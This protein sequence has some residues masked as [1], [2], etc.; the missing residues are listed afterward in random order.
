MILSYVCGDKKT[1]EAIFP[2]KYGKMNNGYKPYVI[3]CNIIIAKYYS[4]DE[5]LSHAITDAEKFV[6]TKASKWQLALVNYLLKLHKKDFDAASAELS[7]FCKLSKRLSSDYIFEEKIAIMALGLYMIADE[8][9]ENT[10]L[11][12]IKMPNEKRFLK[13]FADWRCKNKDP[14]LKL[15]CEYPEDIS[16]LNDIVVEDIPKMILYEKTKNGYTKKYEDHL[17]RYKIFVDNVRRSIKSK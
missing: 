6:S 4:D 8:W 13:E 14:E 3:F 9:L 12:Q 7:A 2:Y 1:R 11:E 16:I 15:F 5:M 10:K 17:E